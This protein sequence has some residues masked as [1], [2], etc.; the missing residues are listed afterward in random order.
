MNKV[1]SCN[2]NKIVCEK[3][4]FDLDT[5]D[6]Q[7]T[8]DMRNMMDYKPQGKRQHL[9]TEHCRTRSHL[10]TENSTELESEKP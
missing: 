8:L 10:R 6:K 9:K 7:R 5:L 3:N 1:P 4:T 2:K